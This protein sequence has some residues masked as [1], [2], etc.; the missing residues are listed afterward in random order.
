MTDLCGVAEDQLA[1]DE[2][3]DGTGANS[4]FADF[5]YG[6]DEEDEEAERAETEYWAGC[7]GA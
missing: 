7:Q 5:I 2:I 1:C 6:A 4:Q 3:F